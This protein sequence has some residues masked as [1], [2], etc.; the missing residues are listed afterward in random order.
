MDVTQE[1][2]I[3]TRNSPIEQLGWAVNDT[4]V[5]IKRD[6]DHWMQ[7]PIYF[8]INLLFPVMMLLMF[9]Y[10]IGGGMVPPDGGDYRA[11]LIPGVLTL[12]MFFGMESTF[13]TLV[14][15]INKGVTD[16]FRSLPMHPSAVILGRAGADMIQSIL[17]L[18]VMAVC[19][20]L[21]GWR[22]QNGL[23]Q[24]LLAFGLLLLLRFS[25]LWLSIFLA[26]LTH[27]PDA[28]MAVQILVWPIGFLSNIF[29]SPDTMPAWLGAIVE[30]SP[31]STTSNAVRLLFGS[32]IWSDN[33]WMIDYAVWLA[34]AWPLALFAIFFPLS[35][36]LYKRLGH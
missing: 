28:V 25:F 35:L 36:R 12:T 34:I 6:I 14:N 1:Y 29:A 22:W 33:R 21:M 15:D 19:G 2:S 10:L 30:W 11:F 18:A 8:L 13:T 24:A 5:L 7:Q 23:D 32:P 17:G 9:G 27:T 3:Q 26:L 4:W 31:L 20:L 16:R